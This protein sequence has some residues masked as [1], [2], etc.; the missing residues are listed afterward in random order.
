LIGVAECLCE[1]VIQ[2]EF[3]E[4]PKPP[5]ETSAHPTKRPSP[6]TSF[7]SS[8]QRQLAEFITTM[9][10]IATA[11]VLLGMSLGG[12]L[13]FAPAPTKMNQLSSKTL[14]LHLMKGDNNE[15]VNKMATVSL[16]AATFLLGNVIS[17]GPAVASSFDDIPDNFSGSS[18]VLAARSGGRAGGR[19][20]GAR[21]M[22]RS[23][24]TFSNTRVIERTRYVAPPVY[25]SPSIIM[26][27]PIYNPLPGYGLGLGL[28]A[29]NQ[30]GNDMRDY[31]QEGEIQD[32]RS[33]LQQARMREAEMEARL[34][35]L[36]MQQGQ[37]NQLT[38][39]Q[40]MMLQQQQ[41]QQQQP[42]AAN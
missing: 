7:G 21:A 40:L 18:H 36:E 12:V 31:R 6:I 22:P 41:L 30:I 27:P 25:S 1:D 28:N 10:C 19:S 24:S 23:T 26:A 37:A 14:S 11:F 34:R 3:N 9:K 29:I 20:A 32:A 5:D 15:G 16:V 8:F 39:Q 17:S 35:Q 4:G 42:V 2:F 33:Q 38:Q 13:G